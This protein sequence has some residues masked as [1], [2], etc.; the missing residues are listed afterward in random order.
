MTDQIEATTTRQH[1]RFD[2]GRSKL[3]DQLPD[4]SGVES[5]VD[6]FQC[7]AE[8][9]LDEQTDEV[10]ASLLSS[11]FALLGHVGTPLG[12]RVVP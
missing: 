7:S 11:L 6:T 12:P 8:A 1:P 10:G 4:P 2:C 3:S 5:R 9:C